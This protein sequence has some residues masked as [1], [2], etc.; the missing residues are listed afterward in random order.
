MAKKHKNCKVIILSSAKTYFEIPA[1]IRF[2]KRFPIYKL[3]SEKTKAAFRTMVLKILGSKGKAQ[4]ALQLQIMAD[5]NTIFTRWAID[6]IVNWKNTIVP[7]NLIHI[8]GT[9]DKLLPYKLVTANYAIKNGEHVMLMDK[10][11][12]ISE[13]LKQLITS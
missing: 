3:H 4:Q 5:S 1:Y 7:S 12:E 2:W 11:A 8:H 9:A 10:A 6:A 13:L